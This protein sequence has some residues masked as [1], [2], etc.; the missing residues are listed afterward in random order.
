MLGA[1]G[2]RR[3]PNRGTGT[4]DRRPARA[5][6]HY[7]QPR[8]LDAQKQILFI[9]SPSVH[10]RSEGKKLFGSGCALLIQFGQFEQQ[11]LQ[12]LVII[13]LVQLILRVAEFVDGQ[14]QFVSPGTDL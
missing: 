12:L 9:D 2:R 3:W 1:R 13:L 14:L 7:F 10:S 8:A 5:V 6:G 11:L 4:F